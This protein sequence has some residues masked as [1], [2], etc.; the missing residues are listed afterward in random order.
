MDPRVVVEVRARTLPDAWPWAILAGIE[1]AAAL[2]RAAA[3]AAEM[4]ALPEGS[5]FHAG[6]PVMTVSG[7]Y[8]DFAALETPLLGLLCE[9]SGIATAAARCRVAAGERTLLSFGAR[10]MHPAITPMIERSAWIGGCD[11]V[12]AV[13]AAEL[14]GIEPAGTMPHALVLVMGDTLRAAEAFDAAF[15]EET[16]T[17]V[18][19]D[20]FQDER[21]ESVRIAEALGDRLDGLRFDT[22]SSRR[23]DLAAIIRETRWELRLR[24]LDGIRFFASGGLDPDAIL[25]LNPVCDGYGVG[26]YI[27]AA[28]TVD[29]SLDIVE[30]DGRPVSKRGKESGRKSLLLC[31]ACGE[32]RVLPAGE[33][34][35]R[36]CLVCGAEMRDALGP[37]PD[38]YPAAAEIRRRA[39]EAIAGLPLTDPAG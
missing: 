30:I 14:L 18:L 19:V 20:T 8:R 16:P 38:P 39:R 36:A 24:G 9:A 15:G 17:I 25:D 29:F 2:L 23:G 27:S 28:R 12:S 21:F 10:R 13:A 35:E 22:P 5:T 26:T 4:E 32:R 3:P 33:R 37:V 34:E 7:R 11:G 31:G 6:E 1:E